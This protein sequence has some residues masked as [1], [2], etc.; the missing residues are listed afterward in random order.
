MARYL[1]SSRT[2]LDI[3][4][5]KG[6]PGEKWLNAAAKRGITAAD[7]CISAVCP[8]A[9]RVEIE[10]LIEK[11]RKNKEEKTGKTDFSLDDLRIMQ[12]NSHEFI[13]EYAKDNRVIEASMSVA[14][15]W[16]DLLDQELEY[17][18]LATN[19]PFLIGSVQKL[20]IATAIVG[21]HDIGFTY[22]ERAQDVHRHIN[23]LVV[24]DPCNS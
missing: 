9:L 11:E 13:Q 18:D 1:L 3:I 23:G 22:V 24:E 7:I 4:Q 17:L 5:R 21:R 10:R 2:M 16:G 8:M 12:R 6:Q 15:R 14:D 19:K 20:E